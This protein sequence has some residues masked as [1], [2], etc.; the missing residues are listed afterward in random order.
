MNKIEFIDILSKRLSGI[1]E[2][3]RKQTIDYYYEIISD[4]MD[5]GMS[6]EDAINS[7]GTI[8]EIVNLTLSEIPFPKLIK[9]KLNLNRKL[10]NWEIIALGFT[11]IV[12]IPLL[13][14]IMAA[15]IVAYVCLWS[16]VIA[17]GVSAISSAATCVVTFLGI[18]DI[19][20]GNVG[21]GL[22]LIGFSL[23]FA[24]LTILLT[25]LTIQL[26]KVMIVICKKL[27]LKVKSLFIKRGEI[28]EK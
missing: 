27:I 9:E 17:L 3:E 18:I 4:K 11:S 10:K 19:F 14:V 7:L 8:D 16:G 1:P 20:T 28:N 22:V 24:G 5:D 26:A 25:I 15:V 23:F 13:I 2:K 6:E 12:W 21:S